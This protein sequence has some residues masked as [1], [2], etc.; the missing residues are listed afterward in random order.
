[1]KLSVLRSY[2]LL[3]LSL[4]L[5][6]ILP[7]AFYLSITPHDYWYYIRIGKDILHDHVIPTVD[8]L[9]YTYAGTPIFYQPWLSAVIFWIVYS[10]G[11]AT[12]TFFLR[13]FCIAIAYAILWTLM[14]AAGTGTK[15]ATLLTVLVGFS[16]ST[17]WSMRPQL[18]A[19]PLF[20]AVLWILWHWQHRRAN[21]LWLLPIFIA[22]WVN[23]HGSFILAFLLMG[24]ALVFGKGDR[25]QLSVWLGLSLLASF[26]S[27]P[28]VFAWRSVADI[29]NSPSI[30][31]YAAEWQP[32]LNLGWQMN[33]FFGWLLLFIPLVAVSPRRLSL[34]EWIWFLG[35]GWLALSGVR[36]VIWFMFIMA[37]WSGALLGELLK[38][39]QRE[40][41]IENSNPGLNF[42]LSLCFFLLP[43]MM[44]PGIR[45]SWWKDS[46]PPYHAATT[47]MEATKWLASH[48]DLPGPMFAEYTFSSYLAFALPS[49]PVWIDNR[50]HVYPP[51]HW[52]KYLAISSAK[53][54][55]ETLLDADRINLLMLSLHSQPTLVEVGE[56]SKQWC[57]QYRDQDAVIFSRCEPIS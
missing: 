41:M 1:M 4:A 38:S 22:L 46:P 3:W 44:L 34:L 15:V 43:L 30:Q 39:F 8:T 27:P 13:G 26:I 50:F 23:L 35:F 37:V 14:R 9:S 19:Y 5:L 11:G 57:Q 48:P 20:A 10:L 47:P 51:E 49:R 45:E 12:L 33:I 40:R 7:I 54:G 53:P 6:C 31:L 52:E 32:P 17:N 24:A 21:T 42:A 18:F 29:F 25:K 16:S 36:N 55:W 28:G 56:A 2:D